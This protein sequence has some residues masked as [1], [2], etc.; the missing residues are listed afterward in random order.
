[1]RKKNRG[2]KEKEKEK[3]QLSRW[4]FPPPPRGGGRSGDSRR[5]WPRHEAQFSRFEGTGS[6]GRRSVV[7]GVGEEG[8][9]RWGGRSGKRAAV[10]TLCDTCAWRHGAGHASTVCSRSRVLSRARRSIPPSLSLLSPSVS[11][12]SSRPLRRP[13]VLLSRRGCSFRARYACIRT[14]S[15]FLA[16]E[17]DYVPNACPFLSLRPSRR[18]RSAMAFYDCPLTSDVSL[19]LSR[20]KKFLQSIHASSPSNKG[21]VPKF[22]TSAEDLQTRDFQRWQWILEN[23]AKD[24]FKL[25]NIEINNLWLFWRKSSKFVLLVCK[26]RLEL[27]ILQFKLFV[28]NIFTL[29]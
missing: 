17:T 4:K 18:G 13:L 5:Y 1:V 27:I 8:A 11:L 29:L 3:Y 25:F 28:R 15:L 9:S 14:N 24:E 22:T 23:A 16:R 2:K 6:A 10:T 21:C 26:F 7:Q 12:T 19:P 20:Y